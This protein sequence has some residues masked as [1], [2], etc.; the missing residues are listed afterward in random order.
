MNGI[1][2]DGTGTIDANGNWKGGHVWSMPFTLNAFSLIGA[3]RYS[4]VNNGSAMQSNGA[5]HWTTL[6]GGT[7]MGAGSTPQSAHYYY[8]GVEVYAIRI[9]RGFLTAAQMLA[10]QKIDNERYGLGL[11]LPNSVS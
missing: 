4:A 10:N 8:S 7:S 6:N 1:F 5:N 11:T 3:N 2:V 9:H